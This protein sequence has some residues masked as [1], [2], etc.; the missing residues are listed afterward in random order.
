MAVR[1]AAGL[2]VAKKKKPVNLSVLRRRGRFGRKQGRKRGLDSVEMCAPDS[3]K[4]KKKVI[5]SA[6]IK[7]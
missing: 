5:I 2:N 6:C 1:I 4:A 7:K 3:T